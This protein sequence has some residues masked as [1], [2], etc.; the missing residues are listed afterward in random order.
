MCLH[1][2]EEARGVDARCLLPSLSMLSQGLLLN[3]S[4]QPAC[5][6]DPLSAL[7]EYWDY[8]RAA[9]R[10]P[11]LLCGYWGAELQIFVIAWQALIQGVFFQ[12]LPSLILTFAVRL[13]VEPERLDCKNHTAGWKSRF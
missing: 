1:V 3:A 9:R 6:G 2:C 10:A 5:L 12:P 11:Q 4:V 13:S 8:G 7:P